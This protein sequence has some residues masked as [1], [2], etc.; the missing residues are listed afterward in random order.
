M[1][2]GVNYNNGVIIAQGILYEPHN[3]INKVCHVG[4]LTMPYS[5]NPNN[6]SIC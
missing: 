5:N 6:N 3:K 4:M 2:R 1:V